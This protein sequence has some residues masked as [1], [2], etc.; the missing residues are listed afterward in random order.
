LFSPALSASVG[1]VLNGNTLAFAMIANEDLNHI[2]NGS[3]LS[4][5]GGSEGFLES[6][7]NA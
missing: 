7:L 1:R 2:C 4:I 3:M 5:G 6:R